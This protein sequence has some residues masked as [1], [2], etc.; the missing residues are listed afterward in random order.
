MGNTNYDT[1]LGKKVGGYARV[2]T[3]EQAEKG[4]SIDEQKRL[5]LE[6]CLQRGWQL[7]QIYC[8]EG[9]S[10]RMTIVRDSANFRGM[11]RWGCFR[12]CPCSPDRTERKEH[13][14]SQQS[15]A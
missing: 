4:T 8:D 11:L 2:S 12:F 10:G 15:L 9:V 1:H 6:E 14:R 5:I 3:F 7:V 13:T